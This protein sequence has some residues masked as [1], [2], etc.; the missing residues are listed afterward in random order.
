MAIGTCG[1]L[2]ALRAA[3]SADGVGDAVRLAPLLHDYAGTVIYFRCPAHRREAELR[4]AACS[5]H[6]NRIALAVEVECFSAA[7]VECVILNQQPDCGQLVATKCHERSED[8]G[9]LW[10]IT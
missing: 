9:A 1:R 2:V 3:K 10:I 4:V 8:G 5:K 7:A 6:S